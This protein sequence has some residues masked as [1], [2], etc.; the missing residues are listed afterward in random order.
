MFAAPSQ[1]QLETSSS[2]LPDAAAEDKANQVAAILSP[3]APPSKQFAIAPSTRL[4]ESDIAA[5]AM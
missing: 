2:S 3:V 5:L 4:K 1:T